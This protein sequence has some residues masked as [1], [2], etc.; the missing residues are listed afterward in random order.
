MGVETAQVSGVT[1][2]EWPP[3]R[4]IVRSTPL[5]NGL[6]FCLFL[7]AY[8]GAYRYALAFSQSVAAPFWFPDSVLLCALLCTPRRWWWLLLLGLL[9]MRLFVE[10]YPGLPIGFLFG[11]Y[12]NDSVKGVLAALVLQRFLSDPIRFNSLR[13]VGIYFLFVVILVSPAPP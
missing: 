5:R 2:T 8:F 1:P 9:P 4:R 13:D 6:A 11:C 3:W 7:L 10:I 12:V